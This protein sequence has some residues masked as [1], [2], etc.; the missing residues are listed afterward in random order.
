MQGDGLVGDRPEAGGSANGVDLFKGDGGLRQGGLEG[1]RLHALALAHAGNLLLDGLVARVDLA[2]AEELGEG[3]LFVPGV[4]QLAPLC[5]V[6]GSCG[7]A[8]AE[9]GGA[10]LEVLGGLGG[11]LLV[12]FEGGV[13]VLACLGIFA[14]LEEGV[15][16]LGTG[17]RCAGRKNGGEGKER[18]PSGTPPKREPAGSRSRNAGRHRT[19]W[20]RRWPFL[21]T[22][23]GGELPKAPE[24]VDPGGNVH[25]TLPHFSKAPRSIGLESRGW[26]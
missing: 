6:L 22:G 24:E 15:R 8:H 2:C 20:R 16:G 1:R 25:P 3:T 12:V 17:R 14:A 19:P 4:E 21:A 13:E 5:E 11:S 10:E 9:K 18:K 23:A 7:D 26:V